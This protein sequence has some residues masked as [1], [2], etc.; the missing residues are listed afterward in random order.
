MK[1]TL[2]SWS[3]GKDSAWALYQLQQMQ[4]IDLV[5]LF[6]T[7]N[8]KFDRIAMHSTRLDLVKMQAS[9]AG[10]PIELIP[11]PFPC[12]RISSDNGINSHVC[13]LIGTRSIS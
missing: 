8:Q 2:L 9:E 5:G 1:K 13:S 7:Y 6:S 3:S 10:L 4:D 12:S 11:L